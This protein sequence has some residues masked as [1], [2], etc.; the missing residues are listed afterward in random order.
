MELFLSLYCTPFQLVNPISLKAAF[1]SQACRLRF[2]EQVFVSCKDGQ[3]LICCVAFGLAQLA[4]AAGF[5]SKLPEQLLS[6]LYGA[7]VAGQGQQHM[8]WWLQE[9]GLLTG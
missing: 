7:A 5:L 6:S 3:D 4:E 8:D 2:E 1:V 9:L